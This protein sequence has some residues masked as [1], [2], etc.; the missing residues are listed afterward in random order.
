MIDTVTLGRI[1]EEALNDSDDME[2]M[3]VITSFTPEEWEAIA[4]VLQ[5]KI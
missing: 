4:L 2:L 3:S 5:G 1:I